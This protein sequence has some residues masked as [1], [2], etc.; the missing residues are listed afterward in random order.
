[1]PGFVDLCK[2]AEMRVHSHEVEKFRR[3]I[4]ELDT[5][6][7]EGKVRQPPIFEVRNVRL[8]AGAICQIRTT[9]AE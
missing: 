1:M 7:R 8:S 2:G 6:R 9:G 5:L 3:E 4:G